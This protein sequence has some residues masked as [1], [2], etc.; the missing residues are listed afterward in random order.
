MQEKSM[1]CG[2][3]ENLDQKKDSRFD[4]RTIFVKNSGGISSKRVCGLLGWI[5][6]LGIFLAAFILDKEVPMYGELIAI[7]AASLL[8]LDSVTGIWSKQVNQ[9]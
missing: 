5:V 2:N 9:Q 7:T 1:N 6:C 3:Q 4:W 8:G